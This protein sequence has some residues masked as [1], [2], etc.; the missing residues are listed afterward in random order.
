MLSN[1]NP[2]FNKGNKCYWGGLPQG[3]ECLSL[4]RWVQDEQKTI[5]ILAHNTNHI[6]Q[7]RQDLKFY[8]PSLNVLLFP[9]YE[10][11]PYDVFS[12]HEDTIAKRLSTLLA[13]K[14]FS[15]GVVVTTVEATLAR[16]CPKRYLEASTIKFKIGD[17]LDLRLFSQQLLALGYY[18]TN[19]VREYGEFSVRGSLLD[20]YPIGAKQPIRIDLFDAKIES[21]RLFDSNNQCTTDKIDAIK[22]LPAKEFSLNNDSINDFLTN[23]KNYFNSED[24]IIF[25]EIS[26]IRIPH[27]IEFYLPLFFD[28]TDTIFD[29]LSSSII[30]VVWQDFANIIHQNLDYINS[31][32]QQAETQG[33]RVLAPRDLFL[34]KEQW[35]ARFNQ[36]KQLQLSVTKKGGNIEYY[37]YNYQLL[38]PLRIEPTH[39]KPLHKLLYFLTKFKKPVLFVSESISRKQTFLSLLNPYH[40]LYEVDSFA[41]FCN[42]KQQLNII[43]GQLDEGVFSDEMIVISERNLFG[44]N[45]VQQRRRRAKHQ[46]FDKPI[47]HLFEL[48]RGDAVVHERYGIG[49]YNGLEVINYDQQ[50]E[51]IVI[52]YAGGDKLMVPIDEL[53]VISR[54]IG[55]DSQHIPLHKLGG[56]QWVKAKQKAQAQLYDLAASLLEI[57]AK[58]ADVDGFAFDEPDDSYKAFV[59][60]FMFEETPDQ[61][62]A[63]DAVIS[64]M[65]SPKPMDR[66]VCG[67]VGFGKTEIAMRAAYLAVASNKQVAVLVPTTLLTNQH[68]YSFADRFANYAV[69]V[70]ALSR[71]ETSATIKRTLAKLKKGDIDI[72]IGTHKLIYDYVQYKNLGLVII[73]EEHRFG[74]KQKESFTQM[75][76][77]CDVLTMSATPIPRTLNMALGQIRD[78]SI[79][80]TPPLGRTAIKTFVKTWSDEMIIEA[81]MREIHRAGQIFIIHNDI[82]S[83]DLLADKVNGLLP[84]INIRIA[85]GKMPSKELA[86]IMGDFYH[87]RFHI[88]LCTTIIENGI[89]IPSANTI[90]IHNAQN[91]GLAQLHQLRGRV[92]RS[93]YQAYAYLIVKPYGSLNADAKKRLNAISSLEQLGSGFMLANYDL[94]IRGAG[95]LLGKDQSGNIQ[96][97]GFNFYQQ[98]LARTI[99]SLKSGS[100]LSGDT[101][102]VKIEAGISCLIPSSYLADAH[103]RL[104]FYKRISSASNEVELDEIKNEMIDRFNKLDEPI[105]ALFAKSRLALVAQRLKA[106]KINL[107]DE[108]MQFTFSKHSPINITIITKLITQQPNIYS[109]MQQDTLVVKKSTPKT[110]ERIIQAKS[111]LMRL[112]EY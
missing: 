33:R 48:N 63:V 83:I 41:D 28:H 85:H 54:Y 40:L 65:C 64:D 22:L 46:D 12:A 112:A 104:V 23:Y 6:E 71:F 7:I 111:V 80:S 50:R 8:A 35:Y 17:E 81:C 75:R 61:I 74:V 32:H 94:E 49:R 89:D 105:D 87:R 13:L 79:I 56:M 16:L 3:S 5:I 14:N 88:L 86:I 31:R 78:L 72:I 91:F 2:I 53:G 19:I 76:P 43:V 24:D 66:L 34:T 29:Y 60:D 108:Q 69:N 26:S 107:T 102:D 9:G 101:N 70:A 62:S 25:Q 27:G 18:K 93:H 15:Y 73:D 51:F 110:I 30:F 1:A 68:Y 106:L 103:D 96:A 11:L 42:S 100:L 95:D 39:L 47:A 92:G 67:D 10:V 45:N 20:L 59:S 38:P 98:L 77:N 82:D 57:Y 44:K 97:I 37:N 99:S 90:I 55:V 4:V 58:R 84:G 109:L 21:I 36:H 52:N